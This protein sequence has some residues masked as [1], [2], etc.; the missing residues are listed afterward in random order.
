MTII[1]FLKARITEDQQLALDA[2]ADDMGQDGGFEDAYD[3]LR[4]EGDLGFVP[5]FGEAAARMI[6]WNTPR[7][8]LAECA[9]KLFIITMHETYAS[10]AAQ[11]TGLDAFGAE[12]GREVTGDVLHPLARV[13]KD[14]PDYRQDWAA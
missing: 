1:E 13:Y 5:R 9:A 4:G 6:V 3:R 12:C 2:I 7:R 10:V 11:R 14:H 8:V